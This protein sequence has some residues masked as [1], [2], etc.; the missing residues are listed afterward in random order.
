MRLNLKSGQQCVRDFFLCLSENFVNWPDVYSYFGFNITHSTSCD[1]CG[2]V[3]SHQTLQSYL[4][5]EVPPED[6]KLSDYVGYFFNTSELIGVYC[7]HGCR[8][9]VQAEKRSKL[10]DASQAEFITVVLTRGIETAQGFKLNV[11]SITS[12]TDLLIW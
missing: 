5:L 12:S 4:E 2:N 3:N 9:I 7:E 1:G 10:T 11:N 8:K 6:S